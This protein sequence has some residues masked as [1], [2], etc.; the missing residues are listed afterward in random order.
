M[1]FISAGHCE[2]RKSKN[3]DPGAVGVDGRIEAV[4]AAKIRNRVI[5]ILFQRGH[6]DII[7]DLDSES[8][9]E[10]LKRIKPGDGSVVVE[11]HFNASVNS[12]STGVEVVVGSDADRLDN[13]FAL[14]LAKA[15]SDILA[16]KLRNGG[17][18][19][20][21]KT[22]RGRLGLM[23]ET[24]IVALVEVGFITNRSDMESFD[25]KFEAICQQYAS[26]I[27]KYDEIIK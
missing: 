19:P 4:E 14:E 5:E 6:T 26:I 11:F 24:G 8:L 12:K 1:K 17:V 9:G 27:Q 7:R 22:H 13:A 15:T 25:A 2:D 10:Y 16:L 3:Y 21:N 18:I 20:E 23:R